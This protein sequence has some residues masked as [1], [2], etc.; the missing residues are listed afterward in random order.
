ML[1]RLKNK[2]ASREQSEN[3]SFW[4]LRHGLSEGNMKGDQCPIMHD[5]PLSPEG[6]EEVRQTIAY[7]TDNN[8]KI[9]DIYTS[10]KARSKET[11]DIIAEEFGL[12]VKIKEGLSERDWGEWKDLCWP[13]A[14]ERLDPMSNDERYTFVP[15]GGES[16]K[17]MEERLFASLEEIAEEN[18][19]GENVLIVMHRGGLRAILPLLAKAGKE[20]HKDYSVPTGG[21]SK[22]SFDKD[23]FDFIGFVPKAL[24]IFSTMSATAGAW[25]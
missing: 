5:T 11:A 13:E 8:I 25:F 18:T 9:T 17:H 2:L 21:L 6:R 4:F 23:S 22:F 15:E 16:W 12:P 14:S 24:A 20:Q 7:F 1:E 10:P 3:I 19:A